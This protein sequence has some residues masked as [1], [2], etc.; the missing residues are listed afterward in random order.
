[1][2]I[3]LYNMDITYLKGGLDILSTTS[4]S[5]SRTFLPCRKSFFEMILG[6]IFWYGFFPLHFT[7]FAHLL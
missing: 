3:A 1:M 5:R 2:R 7:Y 4:A 6:L